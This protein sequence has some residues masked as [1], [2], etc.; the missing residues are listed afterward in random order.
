[1]TS[2]TYKQ[3]AVGG[4]EAGKETPVPGS[5]EDLEPLYGGG[6]PGSN[7]S[8]SLL[9]SRRARNVAG[10]VCLLVISLAIV[11]AV[12]V[13]AVGFARDHDQASDAADGSGG[14]QGTGGGGA[15]A[16]GNA[17]DVPAVQVHCGTVTGVHEKGGV[18]TFKVSNINFF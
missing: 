11:T 17:G 4:A 2:S 13:L 15:S 8:P 12:I 6:G 7:T 14:S 10:G 9:R 5:V 3:L 18:A 16:G 1:M